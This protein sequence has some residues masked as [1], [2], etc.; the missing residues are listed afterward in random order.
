MVVVTP[1]VIGVARPAVGRP[2][3]RSPWGVLPNKMSRLNRWAPWS[4]LPS[5]SRL[6]NRQTNPQ[7]DE[8]THGYGKT[9]S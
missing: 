7:Q 4:K 8:I 5:H 6:E 3:G 1:P 9:I 2:F